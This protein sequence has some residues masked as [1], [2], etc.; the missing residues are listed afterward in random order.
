MGG[1]DPNWRCEAARNG[2]CSAPPA[3]PCAQRLH[4]L[5]YASEVASRAIAAAAL[6]VSKPCGGLRVSPL[7]HPSPGARCP[8]T[9][10]CCPRWCSA[11]AAAGSKWVPATALRCPSKPQGGGSG[12]MLPRVIYAEPVAVAGLACTGE[13]AHAGKER[14]IANP[15]SY[16]C[17][18]APSRQARPA[19]ARQPARN[20]D[21]D[22]SSQ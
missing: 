15:P 16:A 3:Q 4:S 1:R 6:H 9:S 22:R 13:R 8:G 14:H 21:Q 7:T 17:G 2:Q 11:P 10:A 19:A 20:Q 5:R 12:S 18:C